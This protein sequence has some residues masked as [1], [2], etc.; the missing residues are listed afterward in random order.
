MLSQFYPPIIGGEEQHVRNLA[1]GLADRGHEVSVATLRQPG[2][3]RFEMDGK[4]GVHRLA[5]TV[6]RLSSL[7]KDSGRRFAPPLPDP[8]TTLDLRRLM[9]E[10]RPDIVHAHNWL[11]HS[12]LPLKKSTKAR[13]VMT[14][15]DYSLICAQKRL[16]FEG[17]ICDG[18]EIKKCLSC[19]SSF[20][21]LTKGPVTVAG[22]RVQYGF[23]AAAVDMFLPVSRAVAVGNEL[24]KRHLPYTVVPNFVPQDVEQRC[25]PVYPALQS[26]PK[27]PFILFAGD[28]SAD[29][30]VHVLLDAYRMAR[31]PLPLVLIGKSVDAGPLPSIPGLTILERFPHPAVME[32]WK[33][34]AIGVVPSVWA[35][36]CPTVAMEAMA[37]GCAVI[38]S[39]IGGLV[40]IVQDSC[41]GLLCEPGSVAQLAGAIERLSN[42]PALR[43][44]LGDQARLDV[45]NFK[46]DRVVPQIEAAYEALLATANPSA[47]VATT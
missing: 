42:D 36:P 46:A 3:Q 38:A 9:K 37:S 8:E 10:K 29:K 14:L 25:D 24:E 28:L 15:H 23:Q 45:L 33:R 16:I 41:S 39:G 31:N 17:Q 22:L 2:Q 7:F 44:K 11:V 32:V 35:D 30:G 13:L 1:A 18:P 6:Q 47:E 12:F 19:S 27:E 26:L 21:G 5:G 34:A 20:Y 4:V 40:D 43:R